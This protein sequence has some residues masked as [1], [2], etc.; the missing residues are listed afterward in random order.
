[1][2]LA[3]YDVRGASYA[4]RFGASPLC[5]V[6]T[7][8]LYNSSVYCIHSDFADLYTRSCSS[9]P[10]TATRTYAPLAG[11]PAFG[12]PGQNRA[13]LVLARVAPT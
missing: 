7:L 13:V 5:A 11:G 6:F 2:T 4:R 3:M 1:M 10:L 9:A 12:G 8:L